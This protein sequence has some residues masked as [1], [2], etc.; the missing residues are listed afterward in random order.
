MRL[1]QYF[2]PFCTPARAVALTLALFGSGM[3]LSAFGQVP[4]QPPTMPTAQSPQPVV[5]GTPI[6]AD[7][8]VR[9]ALEN[10]LGV[11]EERLN[12]QIAS[13]GIA[14]AA[15]AFAPQLFS[16]VLRSNSAAPPSDFL[17]T[18]GVTGGGAAVVTSGNFQTQAG[19]QQVLRWTGAN[20]SLSWDGS[21]S[22]TDAPRTVFSPELASHLNLNATQPLLRN[23]RIDAF[24]QQLLLS[25]ASSDIADL[26]L[27]QQ[28]TQT[29]R[30][31]RAAYYALTGAIAGLNVA[32]QSLDLAR[33]QLKQNQTRVD[34]GT[35]AP[36]DIVAAEAEVASNEEGVIVQQAAI[37]TAQDQLRALVMNPSQPGFW[38]AR[39]TPSEQPTLSPEAID[40]EA[41][42]RSALTNRTDLQQFK[43]QMEQTDI[44]LRYAAN[45][46]LP[47]IDLQARYG[48]QG[49]GGTQY[50]Y[51]N[52][53]IANG[54]APVPSSSS[55]RPFADVLRDVFGNNFKTWTLQLNVSYPLGT[56]AADAAYAQAKLQKQQQVTT[57][58]DLEMQIATQVRE[59][60]RQV[61]TNL[62]RVEAT[63]KARE[64]AEKRLE[65]EQKRFQVG[66]N[67]T[68]ELFQA[69][70]D[71]AA[72]RNAELN[73]TIAYNLALVDFQA[74][75]HAPLR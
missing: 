56:S 12:P 48:L 18:A 35:M 23:F 5:Q 33:E 73:A 64:L 38:T 29:T 19:V 7:D 11:Q 71:L 51:D 47:G 68:F 75:Q 57:L 43:K 10:N 54:A 37:E 63:R 30:N 62:R 45:Q 39:F 52:A 66:L 4:A 74:V 32:Q 70:R 58:T 28:I 13:L 40:V 15:G 20:Y 67:S 27:Q 26:G 21:R 9:M 1:D 50:A 34:V 17:S 60:G 69:Q 24:R 6:T 61:Q 14:R 59:A 16:S 46:K 65:A 36:I 72:A 8:A 55:V 53:A 44:N 42:V 22:T 41:A 25:R 2:R 49:I 3:P 31:V